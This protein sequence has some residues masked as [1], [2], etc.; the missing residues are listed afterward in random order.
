MES[1]KKKL[2]FIVAKHIPIKDMI[3]R[4]ADKISSLCNYDIVSSDEEYQNLSNKYDY[5]SI[6]L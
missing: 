1:A 5:D 2:L 3:E 6:C 4:H